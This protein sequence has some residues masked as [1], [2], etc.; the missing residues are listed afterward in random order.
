[1][2]CWYGSKQTHVAPAGMAGAA[3]ARSGI[4]GRLRCRWVLLGVHVGLL[5][6]GAES[7]RGGL[8]DG[9]GDHV[10]CQPSV[11]AANDDLWPLSEEFNA[12][13]GLER[14]GDHAAAEGWPSQIGRLDAD[15]TSPGHL[16]LEPVTSSWFEDYRGVFLF[17]ELEGDFVATTRLRV[18][19]RST[20][21]PVRD[22]SFAGLMVRKPRTVT[23]ESWVPGDEDWAFITTG[24]GEG[25]AGSPQ[26]ETK[27]TRDSNST[28]VLSPS[29]NAW[30]ELRIVRVGTVLGMLYRFDDEPWTL[31]QR[32]VREDLPSRVQVGLNAYTDWQ[33]VKTSAPEFNRVRL[34]GPDTQPDL[35]L[36][37]DWVRFRR[38]GATEEQARRLIS[39]SAT[40]AEWACVGG[41]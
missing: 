4:T 20:D 41:D 34:E 15:T 1:M 13:G 9:D 17:K 31:S 27:T 23:P 39:G 26:L 6:C 38:P 12:P 19:G 30:L 11:R 3:G 25:T 8:E 14:W 29:R 33:S 16:Y 2:K 21:V 40:S 5:G 37:S 22:Y 28:L 10:S 18:T 24:F 7:P 35:I 36:R 32:Y